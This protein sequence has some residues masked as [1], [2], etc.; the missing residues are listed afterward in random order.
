MRAL[1]TT[2]TDDGRTAGT[3]LAGLSFDNGDGWVHFVGEVAA[4]GGG[5]SATWRD[6]RVVF[7]GSTSSLE[8]ARET[9]ASAAADDTLVHCQFLTPLTL[10]EQPTRVE[11][12]DWAEVNWDVQAEPRLL[13]A[14][15]V[16]TERRSF[17]LSTEH[18]PLVLP[19]GEYFVSSVSL[20]D[21]VDS[22]VQVRYVFP[23]P[24]ISDG[25]RDSFVPSWPEEPFAIRG[26]ISAEEEQFVHVRLEQWADVNLK[27]T[28]LE[29]DVDVFLTADVND[30]IDYQSTAGDNDPEDIS[31]LLPPESYAIRLTALNEESPYTLELSSAARS[32]QLLNV[33]ETVRGDGEG[34]FALEVTVSTELGVVVTPTASDVDV[35]L[36]DESGR[37]VAQSS[38][39]DVEVDEIPASGRAWNVLR[40]GVSL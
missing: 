38:L 32:S 11:C 31:E 30:D 34:L 37:V 22:G 8:E 20:S 13:A 19:P 28:D 4:A 12:H 7:A 27:L 26:R 14:T 24:R 3:T 1:L 21:R 39:G 15:H 25:R 9:L 6:T 23:R 10:S 29:S 35:Q 33:N 16:F 36:L 5:F 18:R 40:Q 2:P 17:A